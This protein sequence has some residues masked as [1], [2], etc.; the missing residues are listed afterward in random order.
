[1]EVEKYVRKIFFVSDI[2]IFVLKGDVKRQLTNSKDL[3]PVIA[4]FD[5]IPLTAEREN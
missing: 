3:S 2:A 5:K 4:V 1:M